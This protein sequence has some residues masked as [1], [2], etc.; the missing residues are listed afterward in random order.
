MADGVQFFKNQ[1]SGV[2]RYDIIRMA[3]GRFK[4]VLLME[5]RK[6]D[7]DGEKYSRE[8]DAR[9]I[10]LLPNRIP[11]NL[12]ST[13][14]N[15]TNAAFVVCDGANLRISAQQKIFRNRIIKN[16]LGQT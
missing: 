9:Q 1:G 10:D 2:K 16:I 7:E 12:Q 8:S 14:A 3:D 15:C 6:R 4:F 5:E 11:P 13:D